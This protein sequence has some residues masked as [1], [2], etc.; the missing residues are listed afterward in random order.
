[1]LF[2]IYSSI[3][4]ENVAAVDHCDRWTTVLCCIRGIQQKLDKIWKF[5][6]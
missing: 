3:Q 4:I 5:K 6:K 2:M 1:M